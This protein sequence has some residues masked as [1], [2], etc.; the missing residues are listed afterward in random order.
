MLHVL[1][2]CFCAGTIEAPH[3]IL[4]VKLGKRSLAVGPYCSLAN[5]TQCISKYLLRDTGS[6]TQLVGAY[7]KTRNPDILAEEL[8]LAK[9]PSWLELPSKVHKRLKLKLLSK[10]VYRS[11]LLS[12][13][14]DFSNKK[15]V[16]ERAVLAV[17]RAAAKAAPRRPPQPVNWD[18]VVRHN[19]LDHFRSAATVGGF[20]SVRPS[21]V[22]DNADGHRATLANVNGALD[23]HL[24]VD[25]AAAD[26]EFGR[27][28]DMGAN[29][30]PHV[31][32]KGLI[33]RLI[34]PR[35]NLMKTARVPLAAGAKLSAG[36]MAVTIHAD[37][38]D[39][40]GS[41]LISNEA[42][43]ANGESVCLL[44][45]LDGFQSATLLH[46]LSSWSSGELQYTLTNTSCS[47]GEEA[48]HDAVGRLVAAEAFPGNDRHL[49]VGP[50]SSSIYS[51]LADAGLVTYTSDGDHDCAAFTLLG[52]T[53]LSCL[54]PLL[55]KRKVCEVR[56]DL[57]LEDNTSLELALRLADAGWQWDRLPARKAQ[58]LGLKY[59]AGGEKK[60][61]T[62]TTAL[63]RPYL[64]ALLDA[65]RIFAMDVVTFIPHWSPRPFVEYSALLK[66]ILPP[67]LEA[68][69]VLDTDMDIGVAGI[70][71]DGDAEDNA[72]GH[73]DAATEDDVDG[74]SV[75]S[76]AVSAAPDTL[77]ADLAAIMDMDMY[78]APE[79]EVP[80][81][82]SQYE[83]PPAPSQYE[84]PPAQYEDPPAPAQCEDP[85]SVDDPP[86]SQYEAPPSP[87][88]PA[89]EGEEQ[90]LDWNAHMRATCAMQEWG[91]FRFGWKLATHEAH[92]AI[93]VT[94]PFHKK[95]DTT[96]CKKLMQVR[97][98][99][100]ADVAIVFSTLKHWCN[101]AQ[102]TSRQRSHILPFRLDPTLTPPL[103]ILEAH[104]IRNGPA[105]EV[106]TD[107]QLDA[108]AAAEAAEAEVA[109]AA[110]A[111]GP[112]V[113]GHGRGHGSAP[114]ARG[115]G[116]RGQPAV[117]DGR[118]RG[119]R[120]PRRAAAGSGSQASSIMGS[121]SEAES[122][123]PA[124]SDRE[125]PAAAAA[126]ASA[127]G[128]SG[129]SGAAST[130]DNSGSDDSDSD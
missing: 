105:E 94:C 63:T 14:A 76:P 85:P 89:E 72:H 102:Q 101:R 50:E 98:R 107:V 116:R 18:S 3:A 112:I 41:P 64:M 96:N 51:E 62:S 25:P 121:D 21:D 55:N 93:E 19:V 130:P 84:V 125:D 81:A 39:H 56:Y 45:D 36:S 69:P 15:K 40:D 88:A 13:F 1:A 75:N 52:M 71:A 17:T 110:A 54:V 80:P 58:R 97:G 9:H 23:C 68:L 30:N 108:E 73:C 87:A 129:G 77:E 126:S 100:G 103:A 22:P 79:D 74:N 2:T 95:N 106:K 109:M 114:R 44:Q 59:Q 12:L 35:P 78:D 86:P 46:G 65:D 10:L 5:R 26:L 27:D 29:E 70:I 42:T 7:G 92:G 33:F 127:S 82:P 119:A 115:R 91:P 43:T 67:P 49:R 48:L 124:A 53:C 61:Y 128:R 4:N 83:V 123:P 90:D 31:Q 99:S 57:P 28:M 6:W 32:D 60:F 122:P 34:H 118:V 111:G 37:H 120:Q 24:F 113:A 20:Y 8:Q 104:M 16:H 11:D 47:A 38:G 66:G 117:G